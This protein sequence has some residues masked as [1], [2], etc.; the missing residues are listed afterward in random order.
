MV[1][2]TDNVDCGD[3]ANENS[4]NT[5]KKTHVIYTK[6]V[7]FDQQQRFNHRVCFRSK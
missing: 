3:R 5:M 6:H 2:T 1:L 4:G 7:D